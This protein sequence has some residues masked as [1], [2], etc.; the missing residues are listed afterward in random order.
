[1]I[2]GMGRMM[3]RAAD[4]KGQWMPRRY[5]ILLWAVPV[6]VLQWIAI[7]TIDPDGSHVS[8]YVSI[9]FV[10]GSFFGQAT[11]AAAW[12]ALGPGPIRW[13]IPL[14]LVWVAMLPIAIAINLG[15]NSGRA[16]AAI[17]IGACVFGQWL[18]VQ[19]PLWALAF[20]YGLRLRHVDDADPMQDRRER[21]F[22]IRHLMFFTAIVCV[23]FGAGRILIGW[24]GT[25]YFADDDATIFIFL[26][27]A[28]VIL[29]LPL[30]LAGLLPRGAIPAAL[31]VLILIG[32]ATVWE[33]TLLRTVF[34]ASP[35]GPD[36]WHF[37]WIN[38]FTAATILVCVLLL[39]LN[40]YGT[41]GTEQ[42]A[43]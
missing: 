40:G 6:L 21:Q 11:L 15:L 2:R 39:R 1:M 3:P 4:T 31:L 29:T 5:R 30:L 8:E 17:I 28:A 19:L 35:P 9:G 10:V 14:S 7:A 25:S 33:V 18:V 23:I 27:V 34:G 32:L 42:A 13:R 38:C 12:T 16:D 20:G 36:M 37:V 26:A 43:E 24:L 41:A 22:G